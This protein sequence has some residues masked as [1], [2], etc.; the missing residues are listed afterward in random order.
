[1]NRKKIVSL[2]TIIT[3]LLTTFLTFT[4]SA[5]A[6]LREY[7]D[8]P[9]VTRHNSQHSIKDKRGYSWQIVLF[10]VI[11]DKNTKYNLRLV[12]FP[13]VAEFNHPQPLEIITSDGKV[14]MANDIFSKQSPAPNVGQ[15]DLTNILPEFPVQGSLKMILPLTNNQEITLKI[16]TP[17]LLEWQWLSKEM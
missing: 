10:P 2:I 8:S 17:I 1:M 12:G 13:G 7:Q 9:G 4:T 11:T 3:I 14:L 16:A 15:Y 6:T 5:K